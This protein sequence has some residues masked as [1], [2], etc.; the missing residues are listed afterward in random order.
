MSGSVAPKIGNLRLGLIHVASELSKSSTEEVGPQEEEYEAP[1]EMELKQL[2][3]GSEIRVLESVARPGMVKVQ[4]RRTRSPHPGPGLLT[5]KTRTQ[6]NE[7]SKGIQMTIIDPMRDTE[8]KAVVAGVIFYTVLIVAVV[9]T[10]ALAKA[11][12]ADVGALAVGSGGAVAALQPFVG[13]I[14]N[15]YRMKRTLANITNTWVLE[16]NVTLTDARHIMK[17]MQDFLDQATRMPA[18]YLSSA[19]SPP[20]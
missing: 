4:R 17:Q 12:Y 15:Y 8:R 1:T 11:P 5:E 10:G 13:S 16:Q 19:A 9:F 20:K 14:T 2:P 7:I 18:P 6:L 3:P